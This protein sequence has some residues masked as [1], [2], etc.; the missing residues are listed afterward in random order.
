MV[1]V[2]VIL[3]GRNKYLPAKN[4]LYEGTPH[5]KVELACPNSV[6]LA[7]YV[8]YVRSLRSLYFIVLAHYVRYVRSLRSL[9]FIVLA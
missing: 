1:N 3:V 6:L 2:N 5:G 4:V 9:Y 7:H 8:R